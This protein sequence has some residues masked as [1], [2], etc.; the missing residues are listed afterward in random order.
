MLNDSVIEELQRAAAGFLEKHLE[1]CYTYHNAAHTLEVC[2]AA[3]L[4]AELS[5]VPQDTRFALRIAA[6]FHDF[7][8]L[9]RSFDNEQL[10]WPYIQDFGKRFGIDQ[11]ILLAAN[12]MILETVFP[13]APTTWG[14]KLLCDA[15][16]EYIG[17][18]VFFTQ[19]AHFREELSA[20]NVVY[21]DKEWWSLELD[22]LQK[23]SFFTPVCQRL[24]NSGRLSNLKKVR[25]LLLGS[26]G[27]G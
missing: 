1:R 13:Y 7:G 27:K 4:F 16:V 14:G 24:R 2:A 22:F 3:K 21:T 23:N 12:S 5:G 18:E 25:A 17:R 6:I 20:G 9:V 8:Y 19:A 11:N 26:T 10:A 15:D